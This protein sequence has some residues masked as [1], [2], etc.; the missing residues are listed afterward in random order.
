MTGTWMQTVVQSWLIYRISQSSAWLGVITFCSQV[1]AFLMSP[2][3]GVIADHRDRKKI[4][5]RVSMIG[6]AEA[7]LLGILIFTNQIQLWHIATLAV[8]LG[9]VNA[10][11]IITRHAFVIDL[12]AKE[13]LSSAV[14]MNA[15]TFNIA[16]I[17]GPTLAGFLIGR[18]GEAGC[19]FLNAVSFIA[20][21]YSLV[22]V[23][24]HQDSQVTKSPVD[25]HEKL[26][27]PRQL[28]DTWRYIR[29]RPRIYGLLILSVFISFVGFPYAILMPALVKHNLQ[30]NAD[31][32]GWLTGLC[33][34][35]AI[36]GAIWTATRTDRKPIE[37]QLKSGFLWLGFSL[38]FLGLSTT[39]WKSLIACFWLGFFMMGTYPGITTTYQR[40]VDREM[41]GR[42]VS[43]FTMS[44]LGSMPLGSL[45]AGW[46]ADRVGIAG[47]FVGQGSIFLG[48]ALVLVCFYSLK[49]IDLAQ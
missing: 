2:I 47:T 19:F 49:Q 34:A 48:A 29:Q 33:G 4:L 27:I 26:S 12:T 31:V 18:I 20:V 8:V 37:Y 21:I 15:I 36:L 38:I 16:R 17:I 13:D 43:L 30:G 23:H 10:F 39:L 25:P 3:A 35:G 14:A 1:P 46:I 40:L 28:L 24:P 44:F 6:M 5:I 32:L 42:V 7:T 22:Q 9:L 11:E 41:R 45:V